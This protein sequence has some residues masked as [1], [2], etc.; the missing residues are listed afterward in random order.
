M[1]LTTINHT[2]WHPLYHSITPLFIAM[3]SSHCI[4]VC[5]VVL[6]FSCVLIDVT[7]SQ[8]TSALLSVQ[9]LQHN[10]CVC[11]CVS[12]DLIDCIYTHMYVFVNSHWTGHGLVCMNTRC[13]NITTN[14]KPNTR[15][16]VCNIDHHHHHLYRSRSIY[17][18]VC[19]CVLMLQIT[20]CTQVSTITNFIP[21]LASSSHVWLILHSPLSVLFVSIIHCVCMCACSDVC[22]YMH[23]C[24]RKSC[25]RT[26]VR[27]RYMYHSYTIC[28]CVC[29]KRTNN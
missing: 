20:V 3:Y 15:R 21:P 11:V 2:H 7:R 24:T 29:A 26:T 14:T 27:E 23:R 28:V 12:I 8:S 18:H 19:M 9:L 16:Y 6:R 4:N 25:K 5:V 13:V 10:M 22:L 17:V 1:W